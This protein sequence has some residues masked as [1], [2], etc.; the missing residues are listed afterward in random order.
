MPKSPSIYLLFSLDF[1]TEWV[2]ERKNKRIFN[3]KMH[4]LWANI[5]Q[6]KLKTV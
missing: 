6:N 4:K 2:I 5:E 3:P 1:K